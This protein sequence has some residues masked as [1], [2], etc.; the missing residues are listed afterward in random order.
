MSMHEFD[1]QLLQIIYPETILKE[2]KKSFETVS[3]AIFGE[4]SS[5]CFTNSL[6]LFFLL[7]EG[8][9]CLFIQFFH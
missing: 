5:W 3:K 2:G 8:Q 9:R 4:A 1:D 7:F 6:R